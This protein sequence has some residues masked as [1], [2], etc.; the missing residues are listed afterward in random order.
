MLLDVECEIC[1]TMQ[2]THT[3][4]HTHCATWFQIIKI[5]IYSKAQDVL[6]RSLLKDQFTQLN[7]S[8]FS[9]L[10]PVI[11]SHADNFSFVCSSSEVSTLGFL[12]PLE[13]LRFCSLSK[14]VVPICKPVFQRICVYRTNLQNSFV[15]DWITFFRNNKQ[16]KFIQVSS[17][18]QNA[19]TEHN[20]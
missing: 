19:D 1:E 8:I 3:H 9:Y 2:S 14:A 6:M 4:T 20:S 13:F 18:S 7:V 15:R 12:P 10:P 17:R 16:E 11:S 5:V